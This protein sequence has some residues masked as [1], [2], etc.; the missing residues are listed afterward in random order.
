MLVQLYTPCQQQH[1]PC[2][3]RITCVPCCAVPC[4][5]GASKSAK[6]AVYRD[7]SEPGISSA[8]LLSV[9]QVSR[10]AAPHAACIGG[11]HCAGSLRQHETGTTLTHHRHA[12][13]ANTGA[14]VM[15]RLPYACLLRCGCRAGAS[16]RVCLLCGQQKTG[17]ATSKRTTGGAAV[18]TWGMSRWPSP[19]SCKE[20]RS[21]R[22]GRPSSTE[23]CKCL[24]A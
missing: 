16:V 8:R 23:P 3:V 2:C 21:R 10:R 13:K 15:P 24:V 22:P 9:E 5:W 7:I 17:C 19:G 11:C 4:R 6:E 20:P 14:L 1:G 18:S 12:C